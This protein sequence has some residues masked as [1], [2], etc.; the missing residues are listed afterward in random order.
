MGTSTPE[1]CLKE[2]YLNTYL[3]RPYSQFYLCLKEDWLDYDADITTGYPDKMKLVVHT[4]TCEGSG[5]YKDKDS[6]VFDTKLMLPMLFEERE[7]HCIFYFSPV[8]FQE[9]TLGYD[10]VQK[11]F[12]EESIN[13]V[14]H[15]WLRFVS[16]SL[17]MIRAKYRLLKLSVYDEMTGA[18]NRRGM[19]MK[20]EERKMHIKVTR[21]L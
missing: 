18:Y 8:H 14:Y 12:D 21:C 4:T 3:M 6:L 13:V 10:V 9:K 19:K 16:S 7:K 1:E 20:L 5:F 2:I 11:G 17:E 15:S